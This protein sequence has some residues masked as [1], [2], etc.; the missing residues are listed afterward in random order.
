MEGLGEL[1]ETASSSALSLS[2]VEVFGAR[3]VSVIKRV[4]LISDALAG[5]VVVRVGT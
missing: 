1:D 4:L 2:N 5:V 3:T